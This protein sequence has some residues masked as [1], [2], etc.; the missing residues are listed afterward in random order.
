[1]N[2]AHL[3]LERGLTFIRIVVEDVSG[4]LGLGPSLFVSKD[5]VDPVV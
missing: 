1:M 3:Q 2:P 5:K 4:F